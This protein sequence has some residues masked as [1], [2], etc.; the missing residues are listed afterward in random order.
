MMIFNLGV[1]PDAQGCGIAR[2]LLDA[3]ETFAKSG[4]LHTLRLRTHRLMSGTR[5]MYRHLGWQ[6]VETGG[7]AVVME[8]QVTCA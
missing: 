8:K 7:N 6:E 5:A 2:Q 3:A 1:S 4:G